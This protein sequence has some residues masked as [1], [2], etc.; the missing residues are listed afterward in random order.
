MPYCSLHMEICRPRSQCLMS[1]NGMMKGGGCI[2][3]NGTSKDS[4]LDKAISACW[5]LVRGRLNVSVLGKIKHGEETEG[6]K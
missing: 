2:E 4:Y 5:L 1:V 3:G 6:E